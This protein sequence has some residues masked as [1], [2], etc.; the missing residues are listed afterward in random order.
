MNELE[1][2]FKKPTQP[3]AYFY[4]LSGKQGQL[5][6]ID[7]KKN[8]LVARLTGTNLEYRLSA[9]SGEWAGPIAEPPG[10]L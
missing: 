7:W 8:E 9:L 2:T 6:R 10:W 4:R 3:G 5:V 1:W